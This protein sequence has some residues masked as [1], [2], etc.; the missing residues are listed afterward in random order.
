MI[1]RVILTYA[2]GADVPRKRS[3]YKTDAGL[4]D[5]LRFAREWAAYAH[6][7]RVEI[8]ARGYA[9][10]M[11]PTPTAPPAEEPPNLLR[12]A[13]EARKATRDLL[14]KAARRPAPTHA[15]DTPLRFNPLTG[16]TG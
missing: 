7:A 1:H 5:A 2:K 4:D 10:I 3:I 16:K 13:L 9:Q 15:A 14:R 6:V 12:I 11:K 8:R